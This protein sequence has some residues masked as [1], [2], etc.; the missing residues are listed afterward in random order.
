MD[1]LVLHPG[2]L[3]D[4]ILSLPALAALRR[5]FPDATITFAGNLDY[6]PAVCSGYAHRLV[7][8]STLPL[9][10]LFSPDPVPEQDRRFWMSFDR[11]LSWTG[12]GAP[13]FVRNLTS[14]HPCVLV[15]PWRPEAGEARHVSRIFVDSIRP[16]V[17]EQ[18]EIAAPAVS[19]S[20]AAAAQGERW[21]AE[22]GW[23][24]TRLI[25]LHPGAGSRSKR[26]PAENFR[27]LA[28][29]I[30]KSGSQPLVIEGPAEPD[31]FPGSSPSILLARDLSLET[32]AAVLSMCTAFVGNDSGIAH[33]AAALGVPTL[34]L[35]GPTSPEQW[36]PLGRH[37]RILKGH[38]S[39]QITTDHDPC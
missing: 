3:G 1:I 9:H 33:L 15:V 12:S 17:G 5:T 30:L 22:H 2:A 23:N 16:W 31:V 27:Q 38:G 24:H 37:V 13:E 29:G 34:V 19:V 36:A 26:W 6:L 11:V 35:F 7:S 14:S 25:A 8:L 20:P 4:V 39:S 28:A 32:L 18:Q 10:S 21:L